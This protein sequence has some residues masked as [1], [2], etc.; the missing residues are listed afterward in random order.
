MGAPPPPQGMAY[1]QPAATGAGLSVNAASA[2]CYVLGFITGILFLVLEP[3]NR[4]PTV[5]FHAFQSIFLNVAW[6]AVW[7]IRVM[8]SM[9]LGIA[10]FFWMI[11][12]LLWFVIGLGF[13]ILWLY[14]IISAYQGKTVVLPII[15]PL[16]QKQAMGGGGI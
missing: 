2:L 14:M 15:G 12:L 16:A 6:F 9:M 13:F 11:T 5:K 3:Y 8:I 1:Q 4:N 10:G 7:V